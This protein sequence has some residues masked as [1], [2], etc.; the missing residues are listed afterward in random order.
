[1]A[2]A[3]HADEVGDIIG[4]P[5]EGESGKKEPRKSDADQPDEDQGHHIDQGEVAELRCDAVPRRPEDDR[6]AS[7]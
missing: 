4:M 1:M 2:C 3:Q 5:C 6:R 7:T